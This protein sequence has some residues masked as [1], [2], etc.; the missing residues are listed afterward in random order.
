MHFN[1]HK[2]KYFKNVLTYFTFQLWGVRIIIRFDV[3]ASF[4]FMNY[5]GCYII[6]LKLGH[7]SFS[8]CSLSLNISYILFFLVF[9]GYYSSAMNISVYFLR[10]VVWRK[11]KQAFLA[12]HWFE[13]INPNA[14]KAVASLLN[15][16]NSI[17]FVWSTASETGFNLPWDCLVEWSTR[18][19][20]G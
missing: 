10:G 7:W 8:R 2:S 11:S 9:S 1:L 5:F 20:Y 16:L 19:G 3:R 13:K 4:T 14:R 15:L 12:K 6:R 17:L 18:W